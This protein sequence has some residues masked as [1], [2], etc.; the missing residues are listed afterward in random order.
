[1][2]KII[3]IVM[4]AGMLVSCSSNPTLTTTPAE[5]ADSLNYETITMMQSID[6]CDKDSSGCTY[7]EFAYP[8]FINTSGLLA[9]SLTAIIQHTFGDSEKNILSPDSVQHNFIASY[10]AF[11]KKEYIYTTPWFVEK[12]LMVLSQNPK[13]IS[14]VYDERTFTGGAHPNSYK[15]YS[16][17]EKASGRKMILTDFFDSTA[18]YKLMGLGET[19]FRS[20]KGINPNQGLEDAGYWFEKNRFHLNN[21]FYL[22]ENGITFF[23]NHYEV[24]PYSLGSTEITIPANKLVKL[25]KK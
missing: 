4:L 21:N 19:E 6:G 3:S 8:Q 14:L 5:Q 25:M 16:V 13:W 24:G 12:S 2:V 20:V 18:I 10:I 11:K 1:M 15:L 23:F 17:I 9:D 7:I 22:N